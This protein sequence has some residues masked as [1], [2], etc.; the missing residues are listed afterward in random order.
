MGKKSLQ[1]C[2]AISTTFLDVTKVRAND[3]NLAFAKTRLLPFPSCLW[4]FS[5]DREYL[6]ISS[7]AHSTWPPENRKFNL[8][9]DGSLGYLQIVGYQPQ[10]GTDDSEES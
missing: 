10:T 1:R 2:N 7:S 4:K 3:Y 9:G 6:P 5:I 8:G